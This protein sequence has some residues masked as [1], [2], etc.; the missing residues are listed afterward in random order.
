MA[1]TIFAA[2]TTAFISSQTASI[3][4]SAQLEEEMTI[5]RLCENK[6]SEIYLNPPE[7]KESLTISKDTKNFEEEENKDYEYTVEY[8]RF[9]IPDFSKITGQGENAKASGMQAMIFQKM[10]KNLE[11]MIW[12]VSVTVRNKNTDI[13]YTLSTWLDNPVAKVNFN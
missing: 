7:F 12:Q 1:L 13:K 11:E 5:S 4:D 8:K 3:N 10:Q 6:I 2:F 9:K